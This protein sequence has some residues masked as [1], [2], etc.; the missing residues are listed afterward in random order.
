MGLLSRIFVPG[1]PGRYGGA[2]T[3]LHHQ[4]IFWRRINLEVHLIPT[5]AGYR[6]EP[7]FGEMAQLGVIIHEHNQFDVMTRDDVIFSF[8]SSDFLEHLPA[9]N[10]HTRKTVFINCMTWLFD[11][12]KQRTAEGLIGMFLY[13]NEDVLKAQMP[14]LR[15]LNQDP[16][17]QFLTFS[18]FFDDSQ[19]SFVD[20][21]PTD[22]FGCGRISR[23][24]ADKYSRNTLQIYEYF[25][26]PV[27]K[28]GL[29]M[30]F[31]ARSEKKIGRPPHWITTLCDS[32]ILSQQDF[33]RHCRIVLQPSDTT[34]NWPRV[35][36]EAMASG[37][38]LIVDDRG[39]WRHLVDH[40]R[41]GWLCKH[42]RDFIY[43]AS[44]MAY[45]PELRDEM[46]QRA[47][48][49]GR[50]LGGFERAQDSWDAV[51]RALVRLRS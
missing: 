24:D 40:G 34:E 26:A 45:E 28:R 44:K 37:S 6:N 21:R 9:I 18:P 3:E 46:A 8:C 39:G 19:F 32:V 36:F 43:Y 33:Y 1:F 16:D 41:T 4:I 20:K 13:Q 30:G 11:K 14:V 42:E 7:L 48:L 15:A 51:S 2:A 31:D 38:V 10:Q 29:F 12:E 17:I 23:Q 5:N 22:Y 47:Q 25:V 49:R 27:M 50:E 35:G